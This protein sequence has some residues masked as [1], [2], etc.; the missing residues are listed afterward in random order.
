MNG[1][2]WSAQQRQRARQQQRRAAAAPT[3]PRAYG[4]DHSR[5]NDL[6]LNALNARAVITEVGNATPSAVVASVLLFMKVFRHPPRVR[7]YETTPGTRPPMGEGLPQILT[8]GTLNRCRL[9]AGLMPTTWVDTVLRQT[10]RAGT[11]PFP[12]Q[13]C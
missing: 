12:H 2:Q 8:K 11:Y 7:R 3:P 6:A 5:L 1:G 13:D 4:T 10:R 9:L